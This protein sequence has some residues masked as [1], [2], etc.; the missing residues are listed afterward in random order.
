MDLGL[1]S[2]WAAVAVVA[3]AALPASALGATV[4]VTGGV[5]TVRDTTG[6]VNRIS[7]EPWFHD[8][9]GILVTETGS[10]LLTAGGGCILWDEDI[11]HP[12]GDKVFCAGQFFERIVV[13][14]GGANDA[15]SYGVEFSAG[16]LLGG[17][18]DDVLTAWVGEAEL[19]GGPGNDTLSGREGSQVLGGDAGVDTADYSN[20]SSDAV[21]ISL[22]GLANDG[23]RDFEFDN[24]LPSTENVRGSNGGGI[25][26]GSAAANRLEGGAG[27]DD[28]TG[29][30][31]A[32]VLLGFAGDDVVRSADRKRDAEIDCGT[33]LDLAFADHQDPIRKAKHPRATCESVSYVKPVKP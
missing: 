27:N 32:D 28:I 12:R 17:A 7:V 2:R 24:V 25:L 16:T 31:G 18:G 29:G 8:S 30:A 14:A 19:R 21:D 9:D 10:T 1:L 15:I 6:V 22:D 26:V 5:V 3:A 13:D 4:S 23:I 33:G 11:F 20:H